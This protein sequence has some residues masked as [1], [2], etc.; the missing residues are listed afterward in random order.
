MIE[1]DTILDYMPKNGLR[2]VVHQ[3]LKNA[4]F[5]V[6]EIRIR[7]DRP[8]S[9]VSGNKIYFVKPDGALTAGVDKGFIVERFSLNTLFRS[10]CENSVYAYSDEIRQ[11]FVTLRGGHRVGFVGRAICDSD[12]RI[13]NFRDI[14]SVNI[15]IAREIKGSADDIMPYILSG[16]SIKSTLIVSPPGVGK[17]TVLRDM[18]RQLSG[19]GIKVGVADDRGEISA[20]FQGVPC[21]DIGVNT[22]VIENA[23]KSDGINILLRTMSPQVIITDE[24]VTDREVNAV[25]YAK[26][27]GCAIIASVHGSTFEEVKEKPAFLPLFQN[28]VFENLVILSMSNSG[29]RRVETEVRQLK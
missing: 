6:D 11:G 7:T 20:M 8:L 22:D 25:C 3:G 24:L 21:N 4:G 15:R 5:N 23:P 2:T 26:G 17:T 1:Y 10:I 16:T 12:G 29:S 18:A 28:H 19:F 27:S 9:F 14:S 13:E